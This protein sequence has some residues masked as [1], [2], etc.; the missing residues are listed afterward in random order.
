MGSFLTLFILLAVIVYFVKRS[1]K[2]KFF[3]EGKYHNIDDEFNARKKDREQEIDYLLSKM[4][5]NGLDDLSESER[6]RLEELS[7]K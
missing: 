1:Q 6:K 2:N 7:K 3:S 5:K 4:G